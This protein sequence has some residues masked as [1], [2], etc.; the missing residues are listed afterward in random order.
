MTALSMSLLAVATAM[1]SL[2]MFLTA[3]A[4]SGVA[5]SLTFMGGLTLINAV[6]PDRH[7]AASLSAF[8]LVAYFVQGAIAF[9]L[10]LAANAWGLRIAIDIGAAAIAA[11]GLGATTLV[12]I[13]RPSPSE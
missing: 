11:I 1:H 13:G 7:R 5:Y 6:A 8:Y 3:I 9:L 2:A 10:G 4:A 12:V